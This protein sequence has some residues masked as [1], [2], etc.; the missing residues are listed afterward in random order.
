VVDV[1]QVEVEFE[2]DGPAGAEPALPPGVDVGLDA[3]GEVAFEGLGSDE[4]VVITDEDVTS[5]MTDED[6]NRIEVDEDGKSTS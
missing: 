4:D 2:F 6:V 1:L 5:G 3:G